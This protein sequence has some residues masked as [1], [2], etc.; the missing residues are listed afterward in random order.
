MTGK[1]SVT[2]TSTADRFSM[3]PQSTETYFSE[4]RIPLL[5]CDIDWVPFP[6]SL[7][8]G[9]AVECPLGLFGA[10]HRIAE[11]RVQGSIE[12]RLCAAERVAGALKRA[13]CHCSSSIFWS[14]SPA[15][16]YLSPSL[17]TCTQHLGVCPR[18]RHNETI[19]A[20]HGKPSTCTCMF[21]IKG[22]KIT[23]LIENYREF[24]FHF[25]RTWY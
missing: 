21:H 22:V 23:Q 6:L 18:T 3:W 1:V 2:S 14:V 5:G 11:C 7:G 20:C 24:F 25:T 9:K 10:F 13:I 16:L 17:E 19:F 4:G 12:Y 8:L 15:T